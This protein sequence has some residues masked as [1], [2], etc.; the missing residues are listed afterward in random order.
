MSLQSAWNAR[1][2]ACGG[3]QR[4]VFCLRLPL[5]CARKDGYSLHAGTAVHQNDRQGL[6]QLARYCL[7]PPLSQ[8]RLEEAP[9]GSILY[10]MKRRFS[11]GRQVLRFE[12]REF[13]LRLCALVPPR[14]FHMTRY[15]GIFSAH[16]RGRYA[17]TGRG[18]H[19]RRVTAAAAAPNARARRHVATA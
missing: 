4:F 1:R 18:M 11:D 8:G 12:P 16:A 3:R 10:T 17:L 7:R 14:G 13:V 19:D 5:L 15:A 2:P 6:E 9:D